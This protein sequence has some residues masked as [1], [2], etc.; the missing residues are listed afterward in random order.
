M[1]AVKTRLCA[2]L[3]GALCLCAASSARADIVFCNQFPHLVYVAVAYPQT[4]GSDSWISRGWLNV[5]TGDCSEFDTA[6]HV[7]TLYYRAESVS[8]REGGH[9]VRT[10]WGGRGDGSFAI[11]EN[12]NFNYWNAQT[13]V[14][15]STLETFTKAGETTG[16]ALSVRVTFEADGIHVT[17]TTSNSAPSK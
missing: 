13:R 9:S 12:D 1:L 2:C 8:Y 4:D 7:K 15:N 6:L 5:A 17:T 3:I 10:I 14:L 16:E 11:W